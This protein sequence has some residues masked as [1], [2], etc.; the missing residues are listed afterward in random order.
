MKIKPL[1]KQVLCETLR[2]VAET[3][4]SGIILPAQKKVAPTEAIVVACGDDASK[5]IKPGQHILFQK[6]QGEEF[7]FEEKHYMIMEDR[8]IIA[9]LKGGDK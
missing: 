2:D 9:I 1:G 5:A 7:T 6:F 4:I 8:A 3:T